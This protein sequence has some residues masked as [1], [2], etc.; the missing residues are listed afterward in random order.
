MKSI[1]F[2]TGYGLPTPTMSEPQISPS[3][4][5]MSVNADRSD[6]AD[7]ARYRYIRD[8]FFTRNIDLPADF[9]GDV[10]ISPPRSETYEHGIS[11][12]TNP[13]W[14]EDLD[15]LIDAALARR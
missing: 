4:N 11:I 1:R 3:V 13:A 12:M 15:A 7:A 10:I 8:T 14:G 2:V 5:A 6:A 9:T